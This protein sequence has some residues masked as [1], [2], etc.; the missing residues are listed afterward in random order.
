M[1]QE[2]H[3]GHLHGEAT[4]VDTVVIGAGFAGLTAARNLA[5]AGGSVLVLE[6]RDRIGGRTWHEERLGVGIELGGTW[7]HWTQPYVWTEL[8]RYGI[9]TV[10]SPDVRRAVWFEGRRRVDSTVDV[11]T[12]RLDPLCRA[13][14]KQARQWFPRAFE[15]WA[16]PDATLLDDRSVDD[17][18]ATLGLSEEDASLL[19]TFWTLNFNGSTRRGALTQALRWLAAT[20]GDWQVMW[21][22]CAS[23][24]IDGGT[25]V[26]AGALRQDAE[27]RGAAFRLSA[28]VTSVRVT[29]ADSAHVHLRD[30][31]QV[32]ARRV[33][34]T[35]PLHVLGRIDF[36]PALSSPIRAAIEHGQAGRGVKVWFKI[37]GDTTPF[38]ALGEPDWSLNFLQG[39]YPVEDGIVVIGFGP[40][41]DAIDVNDLEHVTAA[42]HRLLP[43]ADVVACTG[44]DWVAD[45][46][47]GETWP[48]HVP[49]H[50]RDSF[51][52]LVEGAGPVRFAGSDYAVGWGGFIDGAIESGVQQARRII[53][54]TAA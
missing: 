10:P 41:A 45:P 28:E 20:N 21:E 2:S 37:V 53:E 19:R 6:A 22:A 34:V 31:T 12:D 29:G 24:K 4:T 32:R 51:P 11:L 54:E 3:H 52:A 44:H 7:V 50:F 14:G 42:V 8:Q 40:D 1:D 33:L 35:A 17:H 39:E 5:D 48:M 43:D 9:G 16:N 15:P 49:G 25:G 36:E 46:Y 13:F 23:T 18:I 38:V 47:A 30:G 27:R 26:L